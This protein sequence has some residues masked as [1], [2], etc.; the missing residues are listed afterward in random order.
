M[1]TVVVR[2]NA[3]PYVPFRP[4]VYR[5]PKRGV[6]KNAPFKRVYVVVRTQKPQQKL[7]T[8]RAQLPKNDRR[9]QVY[10]VRPLLTA[11]VQP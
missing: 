5:N 10:C 3:A 1:K 6:N 9:Q 8:Q 4:K 7:G 11:V 2:A